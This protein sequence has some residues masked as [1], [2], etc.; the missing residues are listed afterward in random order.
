MGG[1]ESGLDAARRSRAA[2]TASRSRSAASGGR[3]AGHFAMADHLDPAAFLQGFHDTAA[4]ADP[5]YFLDFAAGN[6]LTVS[7][8]RQG[9]Q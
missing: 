7:D 2:L 4:E 9:F 5:A 1:E 8:Q 6:R 3:P